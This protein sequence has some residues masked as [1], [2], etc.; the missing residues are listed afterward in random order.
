MKGKKWSNIFL[1]M[2]FLVLS[3][4]LV[5]SHG[6]YIIDIDLSFDKK[7]ESSV[8]SAAK[9]FLTITEEPISFDLD[10]ELINVKF[11]RQLEYSVLVFDKPI[12]ITK[13]E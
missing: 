12:V 3:L 4:S 11:D 10:R 13:L 1:L 9:K 5:Q 7:L 2:V 6:N 8:I